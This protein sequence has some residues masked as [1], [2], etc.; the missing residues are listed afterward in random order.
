MQVN[1]LSG[2]GSKTAGIKMAQKMDSFSINIKNEIARKQKEQQEISSN[3]SLSAEEKMKKRQEIQR[4]INDLYNQ[5]RQHRLSRE[6]KNSRQSGD[7]NGRQ[8]QRAES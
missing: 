3:K 2:A 6:E 1:G 4:Q 7:R 5:L 8:N